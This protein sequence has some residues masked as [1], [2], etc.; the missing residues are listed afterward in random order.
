MVVSGL[1][2]LSKGGFSFFQQG[3]IGAALF[4]FYHSGLGWIEA[5]ASIGFNRP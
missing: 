2:I 1:F 5:Q 4:P 3:N